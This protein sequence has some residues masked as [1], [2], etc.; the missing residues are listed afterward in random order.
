VVKGLLVAV[1]VFVG[2]YLY[3]DH[4]VTRAL[5]EALAELDRKDPGWRLADIEA[6]RAVVPDDENGALC[7]S[8]AADRLPAAAFR[9][10]PQW[11]PMEI[12]AALHNI[13]G[14]D[15]LSAELSARLRACFDA[16]QPARVEALKLADRP[17]GR[18]PLAY[19][20]VL[21][22]TV[23]EEQSKIPAVTELLSGE[24][25]LCG[26]A[27]DWT[28]AVRACRAALNAG[29]SLGDEPLGLS[30]ITLRSDAV[31]RACRLAAWVLSQGEVRPAD[32]AALQQALESEVQHPDLQIAYRGERAFLNEFF[33][34]VER[35]DVSLSE[36]ASR[37]PAW[38]DVLQGWYFRHKIRAGHPLFLEFMT[39]VIDTAHLPS[40]EQ[41]AAEKA[42]LSDLRKPNRENGTLLRLVPAFQDMG[43]A[44]R[45]KQAW[46]RSTVAAL[47]AE[48]YRRKHGTWPATLANLVPE[49]LGAVPTDPYDGMPLRYQRLADGVVIYSVGSDRKDDGGNLYRWDKPPPGS[50]V[51]CRLWDVAQRRRTPRPAAAGPAR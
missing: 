51:G 43:A 26:E 10:A 1:A 23:L 9:V 21:I 27:G 45:H 34:A 24:A 3:R 47:A 50:D 29:R 48:R 44:W 25:L 49:H 2:H 12:A 18:Y 8:A 20:R 6:A 15:R 36:F 32:L 13:E 41:Q 19:Q 28:G 33:L 40:A 38:A 5:D 7:V 31:V 16:V 42:I 46:L 14:P 30:Q 35:G 22:D 11:P 4:Q 39:L 37:S 17:S